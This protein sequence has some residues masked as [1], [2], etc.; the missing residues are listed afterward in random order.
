MMSKATRNTYF[1][2]FYKAKT[3]EVSG[4]TL[5]IFCADTT[6]HH[7]SFKNSAEA[8]QESSH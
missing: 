2:C 4:K 8:A 5:Y 1:K 7:C 3:T 6:G